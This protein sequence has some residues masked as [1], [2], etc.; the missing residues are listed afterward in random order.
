MPYS[1]T[2]T[3]APLHA[4]LYFSRYGPRLSS[5]PLGFC[6]TQPLLD[7]LVGVGSPHGA[8][9]RVRQRLSALLAQPLAKS[10]RVAL[11]Q[12]VA[13]VAKDVLRTADDIGAPTSDAEGNTFG[14]IVVSD[15]NSSYNHL[16][17][18]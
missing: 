17:N 2:S 13:Y 6:K 11:Q 3:C 1:S 9:L 4:A 10:L 8:I 18:Q 5:I 16:P 15:R 12:M 14:A 7:Q